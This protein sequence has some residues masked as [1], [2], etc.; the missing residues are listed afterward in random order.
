MTADDFSNL[1]ALSQVTPGPIAINAAT[2]VGYRAAGIAGGIVATVAVSLPSFILIITALAFINHF[3]SN[4][5]LKSLFA[6][7]VPATVGLMASAFLFMM[8]TALL[9]PTAA[10]ASLTNL[11]DHV[12]WLGVAIFAISLILIKLRR[13]GAIEITL[14][15]G[16]LAAIAKLII[17]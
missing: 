5:I 1:V 15:G 14:I 3:R 6:G 4:R 7:I 11:I 9:R 16:A 2:Y 8:H 17:G 10:G 13:I 12:E